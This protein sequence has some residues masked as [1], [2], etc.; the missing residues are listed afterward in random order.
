MHNCPLFNAGNWIRKAIPEPTH[1]D[2]CTQLGVHMEEFSEFLDEIYNTDL[3]TDAL[4]VEVK[5]KLQELAKQT[6][7]SVTTHIYSR[8]KLL[9]ALC[10]NIQTA[11][12][13]SHCADMDLANAMEHIVDS[14]F[15]KFVDNEPIFDENR[16]VMKGPNYFKPNLSRFV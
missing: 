16:K 10:D 6:K 15:S 5:E 7:Q 9:D 12:S 13:V 11:A 2:L 8:E 3:V 1:K 4:L 14:N